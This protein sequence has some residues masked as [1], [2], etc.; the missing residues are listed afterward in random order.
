VGWAYFKRGLSQSRLGQTANARA[1]FET[2][3]K[4][5]PDT[6]PAVMALTRLQALDTTPAPATPPRRP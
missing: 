2:V 3:V 5:F 6:E 1:S 4:Q